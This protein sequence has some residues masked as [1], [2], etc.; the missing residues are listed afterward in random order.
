[1]EHGWDG[2]PGGACNARMKEPP[3]YC[4]HLSYLGRHLIMVCGLNNAY[5]WIL[6]VSI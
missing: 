2:V 3:G 5:L 6:F 1:M 4:H